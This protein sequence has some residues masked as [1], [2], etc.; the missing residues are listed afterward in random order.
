MEK[1]CESCKR[2]FI[3]HPAVRDQ[4]YCS[5]PECQKARKRK[6]QKS[7]TAVTVRVLRCSRQ[8]SIGKTSAIT[9]VIPSSPPR[10]LTAWCI[11]PSSSISRDP[12]GECTNQRSSTL[13]QRKQNQKR[14]SCSPLPSLLSPVPSRSSLHENLNKKTWSPMT[15]DIKHRR[16]SLNRCFPPHKV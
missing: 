4:R 8:I 15:T 7:S 14:S 13:R 5:N 6:W 2:R 3:P 9:S 1:R 10:L 11:I 16:G 12:V